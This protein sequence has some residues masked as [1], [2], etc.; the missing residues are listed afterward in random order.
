MQ[1]IRPFLEGARQT[2]SYMQDGYRLIGRA[3]DYPGELSYILRHNNGNKIKV[4][5][6]E[7]EVFVLVNDK[8]KKHVI[9]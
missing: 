7:H 1:D 6:T 4:K 5:I 3:S 9:Y 8:V 2:Q